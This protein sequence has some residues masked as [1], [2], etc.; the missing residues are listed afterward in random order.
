MIGGIKRFFYSFFYVE[1]EER[2]K[3]ILLSTAFFLVIGGYSIARELKNS[4]FVSIVGREYLGYARIGVMIALMPLI[5]LYSRLV[6]V[7]RRHQ[8]LY[9]YSVLYGISGLIFAYFLGHAV[10]GIPNTDTGPHRLFGWFFYL[11]VEGYS[12][13][14]VSLVWAFA[15]S[16]NNPTTASKYYPLMVGAS[17]V[18]GILSTGIGWILFT[19]LSTHPGH[20]LTGIQAHQLLLAFSSCLLLLI[21]LSIYLLMKW[22]P[23]K[24]LHGYEAAYQTDRQVDK[25]RRAAERQS[26]LKRMRVMIE[27][28]FSGLVLFVRQPYILGIF[29]TIFFYETI[30][31]LFELQRLG[32]VK[33]SSDTLEAFSAELFKQIFFVHVTGWLIAMFCTKILLQKLGERNCLILMPLSMAFLMTYYL[34]SYN[35]TAIFIVYVI[36]RAMNYG[37]AYPIR[38]ALYIPTVKDIKFKSKSWIDAFGSKMAKATGASC[39][40]FIENMGPA[41]FFT[42]HALI[43]SVLI[44]LWLVASV[45]LGNRYVRAIENNEVIG[46]TSA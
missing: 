14:V 43:F 25:E 27:G 29:C 24:S 15:N 39:S 26:L 37:F 30:N 35:V 11:F 41:L 31:V 16:V 36:F 17:K 9:F 44:G 22:V 32:V 8:L 12:P 21:P 42:G 19:L 7:L 33:A 3:V 10:I 18:G 4:V 40:I 46:E 20:Y 38:E 23:N 13:F 2:L 45:L 28:M 5:L 34:F 1:K 6:D